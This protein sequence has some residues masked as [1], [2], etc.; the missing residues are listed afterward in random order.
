[1]QAYAPSS[2]AIEAKVKWFYQDLLEQTPKQDVLFIIGDWNAK[3]GSQEMSGVT[4]RFSLGVQNGA[5]QRLTEFS[6]S[7]H[8]LP[9][10][11]EVTSPDIWSIPKSD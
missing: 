6:H 2:N 7:K 11:Q 1:M 3:M 10:T 5:R 4:G 9:T 8:P